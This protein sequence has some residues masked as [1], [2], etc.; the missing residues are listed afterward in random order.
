MTTKTLFQQ[1]LIQLK[2]WWDNNEIYRADGMVRSLIQTSMNNILGQVDIYAKSPIL[3]F[4]LQVCLS[5]QA[6]YF[7]KPF[8]EVSCFYFVSR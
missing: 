8:V 6:G 2:S 3:I 4:T 1:E 7:N 5:Y